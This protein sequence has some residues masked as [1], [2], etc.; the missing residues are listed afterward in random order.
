MIGACVLMVPCPER[1]GVQKG[2]V[3]MIW[4]EMAFWL[5]SMQIWSLL[6]SPRARADLGESSLR[7]RAH[8]SWPALIVDCESRFIG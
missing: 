7:I 5:L 8:T 1:E 4:V 6:E 3:W 2:C